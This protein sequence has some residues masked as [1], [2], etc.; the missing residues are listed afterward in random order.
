MRPGTDLIL[1]H[2]LQK[3][4]VGFQLQLNGKPSE[5]AILIDPKSRLKTLIEN[6]TNE[7]VYLKKLS[8]RNP[9]FAMIPSTTDGTTDP[10]HPSDPTSACWKEIQSYYQNHYEEWQNQ[11]NQNCREVMVCLTCPRA[12]IGLYVLYVIKP[13]NIKCLKVAIAEMQYTLFDF[14]G[15]D[16]DSNAVAAFIEKM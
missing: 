6:D 8:D 9:V 14:P 10:V 12:G 15:D 1:D 7:T 3:Y 2:C 11:A 4:A 5:K 13:N 16:S